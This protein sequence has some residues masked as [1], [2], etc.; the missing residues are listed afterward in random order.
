MPDA[1]APSAPAAATPTG[2]AQPAPQTQVANGNGKAPTTK[3]SPRSTDGRYS[4]KEGAQGAVAQEGKET[5]TAAEVKEEKRRMALKL[6]YY[7]QE[8]AWE[9]NEDDVR[10][11]IQTGRAERARRERLEGQLRERLEIDKLAKENPREYLRR[12]GQDP[13][14][15]AKQR[16][17]ELVDYETMSDEARK[18]H[19]AERRASDAESKLKAVEEREK[20]AR[21]QQQTQRMAQKR[22]GEYRAALATVGINPD[23]PST[24]ADAREMIISMAQTERDL[25]FDGEGR[26]V[27][28]FTPEELAQ[29]TIRRQDSN[30]ERYLTRMDDKSLYTRLE[31]TGRLKGILAASIAAWEAQQTSPVPRTR[32]AVARPP[33]GPTQTYT[34]EAEV[35]RNMKALFRKR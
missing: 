32:D 5:A 11:E 12:I 13:D 17:A 16:I 26:R 30:V 10:R 6:K 2:P 25:C 18:A 15:F 14:A 23:E 27:L 1:A 28:T 8:E 35:D 9:G 34:S 4:P 22:M 3:P 31:K 7:G 20:A 29:E 33:D 19:D 21:L 24:H